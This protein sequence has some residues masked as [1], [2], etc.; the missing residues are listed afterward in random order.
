MNSLLNAI[1]LIKNNPSKY[2]GDIQGINMNDPNA[3]IQQGLNSGKWTQEQYNNAVKQA[4][5]MGLIK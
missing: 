2:F 3:I 1:S 4:K 5:Q